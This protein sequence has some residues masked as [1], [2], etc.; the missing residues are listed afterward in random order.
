M[1]EIQKENKTSEITKMM[2]GLEV[3]KNLENKPQETKLKV[4]KVEIIASTSEDNSDEGEDLLAGKKEN[5][6]QKKVKKEEKFIEKLDLTKAEEILE[7]VDNKNSETFNILSNRNFTK[8]F[9]A[10]LSNQYISDEL[11]NR[12]KEFQ[13]MV[14]KKKITFTLMNN[15]I[16]T[17]IRYYKL[18]VS[19]LALQS[20]N[21]KVK[22]DVE[23]IT[24]VLK[25]F[26]LKNKQTV[27]ENTKHIILEK[28][29]G[30][31][32]FNITLSCEDIHLFDIFE[33]VSLNNLEEVLPEAKT[34]FTDIYT[35]WVLILILALSLDKTDYVVDPE[36]KKTHIDVLREK[37]TLLNTDSS[38][39]RVKSLINI[40]KKEK[41]AISKPKK[42][43]E[44]VSEED[45]KAIKSLDLKKNNKTGGKKTSHINVD[46][47]AMD[48]EIESD[49]AEVEEVLD[50]DIEITQ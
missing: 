4:E 19:T 31:Y 11:K 18:N 22:G 13:S 1:S 6:K 46:H 38:N 8:L 40:I 16:T 34:V 7:D 12:T 49:F 26:I 41:T 23:N 2:N 25:A 37:I 42:V 14:E 3:D 20:Y 29:P 45:Q 21:D 43:K 39:P 36:L 17:I 15:L 24:R 50:G 9:D 5:K 28:K 44:V 35:T 48:I 32:E 27:Y 33:K 47:S 30:G 10:L